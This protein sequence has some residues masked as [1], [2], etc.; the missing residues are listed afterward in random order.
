MSYLEVRWHGRGGQGA[1]TAAQI[2]AYAAIREGKYAQ[3]FPTFGPE[4]R[5]APVAAFTRISNQHIYVRS[6]IYEPDVVVVLD[7]TLLEIPSTL[8]GLKQ[9]GTL[10]VNTSLKPGELRSRVGFSGKIAT[11]NATKIALEE[12]NRP[13]VNTTLIGAFIKSTMAVKFETVSDV[14]LKTWPGKIGQKNLKA[15][16]RA[17]NETIVEG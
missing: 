5:G 9:S 14:I 6:E 7:E 3:A 4:R 13:I 2:I 15:A 16:K 11:V 8:E 17:L 12:L 1:V 10:I